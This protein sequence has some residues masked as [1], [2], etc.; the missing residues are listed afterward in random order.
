MSDAEI[1]TPVE[2]RPVPDFA[3]YRVGDDGSVW[4]R[5]VSGHR[6]VLRDEWRRLTPQTS[7]TRPE[8][9]AL[10]LCADGRRRTVMVH[11]L[12]LEVFVSPCPDGMEACHFPDP[13]KQNNSLRNLRWGTRASNEADKVVHGTSNRG[14]RHGMAKL[15]PQDVTEIRRLHADGARFATLA[16]QF[17]VHC[18]TIRHIIIRKTWRHIE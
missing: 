13:C 11:R 9:G 1:T 15:T 17:K 2:Y 3:G 10:T 14:E 4:S 7:S 6:G 16:R 18:V 12:V 5:L 8:Y